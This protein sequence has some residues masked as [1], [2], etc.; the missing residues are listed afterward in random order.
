MDSTRL[1]EYVIVPFINGISDH[2]G[3]LL[4]IHNIQD[5]R[6]DDQLRIIKR[7]IINQITVNELN[8]KLSFESWDNVFDTNDVDIM[9]NCFLRTFLIL[10][11]VTV[12]TTT[13]KS[14]GILE[15]TWITSTI[16]FLSGCKKDRYFL[17]KNYDCQIF[18][19][20]YKLTC[21]KLKK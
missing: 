10:F 1:E 7:N 21:T 20:K 14:Q 18:K 3:Q 15:N 17:N 5:K 9:Y 11:N 6:R 12:R 4:S 19:D 8:Y 2:D 13:I 16:K